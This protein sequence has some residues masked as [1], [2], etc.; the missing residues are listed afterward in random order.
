MHE[1]TNPPSVLGDRN[2][3]RIMAVLTLIASIAAI[4]ITARVNPLRGDSAEYLYFDPSRTVGYP[5]F[6]SLVRFLTGKVALAV[7]LQI[8]ILG[9]SLLFLAWS[10]HQLVRR[11]YAS[12]SFLAF[13]L[14]QAGMWFAAAFLMTEALST[15]LVACWCGQLLRIIKAPQLRGTAILVAV[16]LAAT[17]VRPSLVALF[18][19]SIL[20]ILLGLEKRVRI[21][22]LLFAVLAFLCSWAATP[23]AQLV[24]HGS[25]K[26]TSPLARG[27]LQHS[28]YCTPSNPNGDA[29]FNFV[30]QSAAPVRRY[31]DAA[32]SAMHEQFRRAYST[33]L[34]FGLIIPVLGRRHGILVRSGVDPFLAPIAAA[35]IKANPPCYVQSAVNEYLRLAAFDTDPTSEDAARINYYM[36]S[37]PAPELTQYPVLPG[38]RQMAMMAAKEVN[39]RPSGLTPP[40]WNMKVVGDVPLLALLPMRLVYVFASLAGLLWIMFLIARPRL[41]KA[42]RQLL[43]ATAALGIAF[44]GALVI[45]AIVEIG[46]YRYLMPLWPMVCTLVFLAVLGAADLIS[47]GQAK[48]ILAAPRSVRN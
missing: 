28:L 36:K 22:A 8:L 26:T 38:D 13:L 43:P 41:S 4:A 42:Q 3:F 9:G 24:V 11:P 30:E 19:G 37:H 5:L 20:F 32:P 14:L 31:I 39:G 15:A 45:T 16:S 18:F 44:H 12:L 33:P 48:L 34:R 25:A 7:P 23:L 47:R 46:F 21:S 40:V 27:V 17:M 2:I 35:R 1:K 29:D 10:F 6:L